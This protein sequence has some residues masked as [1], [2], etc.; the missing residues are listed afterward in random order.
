MESKFYKRKIFIIP[1]VLLASLIIVTALVVVST[2]SVDV[3]VNEALTTTTVT[4]SVS[5]EAGETI[6]QPI[7][8]E[9]IANVPLEV[10]VTFIEINNS[11]L[12]DYV[13][14]MPLTTTL[15]PGDNIVDVSWTINP[16]SPVGIFTGE[17]EITR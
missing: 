14:N 6:V 3:T 15:N 1:T 9:N 8:I 7:D 12:V 5:G 13:T 2:I 10:T 17:I 4:A 16:S 11:D